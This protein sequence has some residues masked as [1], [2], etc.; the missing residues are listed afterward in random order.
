M[1]PTDENQHGSTRP[2]LMSSGTRRGGGED[3]ILAMLERNAER[4]R[5]GSPRMAWYL[6]G[7]V[8]V[9]FLTV[10]L[11]WLLR[12]NAASQD[13]H[14]VQMP[15]PVPDP[16]PPTAAA[17]PEVKPVAA[18]VAP[19]VLAA[20]IIDDPQPAVR[21][22]EPK[23]AQEAT[24]AHEER[25]PLVLLSP[26]EAETGRPAGPV[27]EVAA[28]AQPRESAKAP[29]RKI[30]RAD[31]REAVPAREAPAVRTV[32][33]VQASKPAPR[34]HP[35]VAASAVP[36]TATRATAPARARKPHPAGAGRASEAP[37]DSDVALISAIISHSPAH[38]AER[39]NAAGCTASDDKKCAG[40]P[41]S[42]P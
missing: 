8:L 2:N 19:P 5:L 7:A 23:A 3:N 21:A 15:A 18:P 24:P 6:S 17:A 9:V 35:A 41:A 31:V 32:R 40:A 27:H 4:G 37:V 20:T 39:A 25:P 28:K 26:A 14:G 42:R 22:A 10:A 16:V 33:T 34:A 1:R 11:A 12:E 13:L 38:A 36:K 30:A 29:P